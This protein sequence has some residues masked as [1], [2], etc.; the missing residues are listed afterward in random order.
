MT[1][2]IDIDR[3]ADLFPEFNT[4][5]AVTAA[6]C[7]AAELQVNRHI[8]HKPGDHVSLEGLLVKQ[9]IRLP[10]VGP[11]AAALANVTPD[12]IQITI[13]GPLSPPVLNSNTFQGNSIQSILTSIFQPVLINYFE[14]NRDK[15]EAKYGSDRTKWPSAWQMGWLV[16]NGLSHGNKVF[17]ERPTASPVTWGGASLGPSD[18]GKQ[19][20]FGLINQADILFLLF[21]MEDTLF[22]ALVRRAI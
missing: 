21:E 3:S 8:N 6:F 11:I 17:F 9:S 13:D 16:R 2:E 18:N 22:K 19:L 4:L 1:T 12:S 10:L 5:V 15:L 7:I 14:R 20:V